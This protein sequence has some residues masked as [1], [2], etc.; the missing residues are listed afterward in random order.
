MSFAARIT[1]APRQNGM[2]ILRL[3]LAVLVLIVFGAGATT[4]Q[5]QPVHP[6][7]SGTWKLNVTKSK[8]PKGASASAQTVHID[9]TG[10]TILMNV[11]ADNTEQFEKFVTDGEQHV[12]SQTSGTVLESGGDRLIHVAY[13]KKSVLITEV[14]M[15]DVTDAGAAI[16]LS[17]VIE[18]WTVP[19]HLTR[20]GKFNSSF[21]LPITPILLRLHQRED[22]GTFGIS[23]PLN[24][25]AE[26]PL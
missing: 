21:G 16:P 6:D 4:G 19:C 24:Y 23:Q 13:W 10:S 5:T 9:C 8:I 17:T 7:L 20:N 15:V 14:I 3:L 26:L 2:R 12:V 25:V 22:A 18:H 1:I 11:T